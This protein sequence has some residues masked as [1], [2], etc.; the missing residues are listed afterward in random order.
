LIWIWRHCF[1]DATPMDPLYHCVWRKRRRRTGSKR[2]KLSSSR[3]DPFGPA[4]A[5]PTTRPPIIWFEPPPEVD[6]SVVSAVRPSIDTVRHGEGMKK[7]YMNIYDLKNELF[8]ESDS[9]S[10]Q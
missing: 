3:F 7:E 5:I 1:D 10:A 6:I 8:R 9:N 4:I 2:E